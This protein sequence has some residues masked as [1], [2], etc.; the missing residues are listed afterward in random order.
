MSNTEQQQTQKQHNKTYKYKH[1]TTKHTQKPTTTT[2]HIP[3]NKTYKQNTHKKT[4]T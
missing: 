2:T 3:F 4:Q 1:N